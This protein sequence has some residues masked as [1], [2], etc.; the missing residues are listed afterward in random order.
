MCSIKFN[1]F[2]LLLQALVFILA[3]STASAT[4]WDYKQHTKINWRDYNA[5]TFSKAKQEN[6]PLY[7]FVYS[8]QCSWCQKFETQTLE[9][10]GVREILEKE[11]IPIAINQV[12]NPELVSKLGI[13]L[14]PGNILLTPE[15]KKL[16]R[17]YG[18][19]A[20]ETFSIVLNKTLESWRRGELPEEEFGDEKTCCPLP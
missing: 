15:R 8:N 7:I 12:D 6:K 5:S 2:S 14:I 19:I 17:F 18:Y 20:E 3:I 16:L 11:F 10:K 4:S 1:R 9:K 13:K